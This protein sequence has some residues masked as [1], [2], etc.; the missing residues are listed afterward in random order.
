MRDIA[1][2]D[3]ADRDAAAIEFHIILIACFDLDITTPVEASVGENVTITAGGN[4][5]VNVNSEE[6][7]RALAIAGSGGLLAGA[8]AYG[9]VANA[10]ARSA[11]LRTGVNITSANAVNVI[12]NHTAD[13][14]ATSGSGT[15]GLAVAGISGANVSSAAKVEAFTQDVSIGSDLNRVGNININ[16]TSDINN[17]RNGRMAHAVGVSGGVI[18]ATGTDARASINPEVVASIGANSNV[19]SNGAVNVIGLAD[20]E[21]KAAALGID[22]GI[23]AFG[24]TFATSVIDPNVQAV[25]GDRTVI[26]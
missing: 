15:I 1:D 5:K 26:V 11:S 25:V 9:R 8:G 3:F 2:A 13:F 14:L 6:S 16:A 10:G 19:Y 4:V 12:S 24:A 22:V 7:L 17:N 18:T 21:A 23:A 20:Q